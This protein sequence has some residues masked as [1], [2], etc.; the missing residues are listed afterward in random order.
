[1][2]VGAMGGV[3]TGGTTTAMQLSWQPE[4]PELDQ[5]DAGRLNLSC[6]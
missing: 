4:L 5:S 3:V 6:G 1:M 2:Q